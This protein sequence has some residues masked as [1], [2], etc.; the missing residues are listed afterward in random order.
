MYRLDIVSNSLGGGCGGSHPYQVA[1]SNLRRYANPGWKFRT[2]AN[3]E[4][5]IPRVSREY[6]PFRPSHKD[7]PPVHTTTT[8]TLDTGFGG[9]ASRTLL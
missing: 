6:L 1:L 3:A 4:L 8:T 5:W 7:H 2:R 9:R